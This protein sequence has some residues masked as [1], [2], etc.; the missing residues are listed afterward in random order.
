MAVLIGKVPKVRFLRAFMK[1]FDLK[2]FSGSG[3]FCNLTKILKKYHKVHYF[4][5]FL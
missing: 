3:I 1:L 5:P 4:L 2:V